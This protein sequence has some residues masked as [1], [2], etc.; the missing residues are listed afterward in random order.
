MSP[1][2][3]GEDDARAAIGADHFESVATHLTTTV[4]SHLPF[5]AL[6]AYKTKLKHYFSRRPWT[7]HDEAALSK[8][9]APYVPEG[10]WHYEPTPGLAI[11][12]GTVDGVYA[13]AAS[14]DAEMELDPFDRVFSG[15]VS[16]EPTPHPRKVRFIFGGPQAPGAWYLQGEPAADPRAQAL[17]ADPQVS[18]VMI[19]GDFVTIGLGPGASWRDRL[20]DMVERVTELFA[21]GADRAADIRTRDELLHDAAGTT[22]E[23]TE[24]HLLDPD[25]PDHRSV[26]QRALTATDYKKRRTAVAV[27]AQSADVA[28]RDEAIRRGYEDTHLSVRRTAIDEAREDRDRGLL[29]GALHD[30]DPWTR[31]RAVRNLSDLGIAE[32]TDDVGALEADENFQVRFEVARALKMP[33]PNEEQQ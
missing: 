7:A 5:E 32:S 9:V 12:H 33:P 11:E 14:G 20:D 6:V 16:P 27:L 26:L 19:A 1:L 31:W 28:V 3:P 15:P 10:S 23:R 21:E 2:S 29:E 25:R 18:D 22:S 13:L 30:R 17:L 4:A 24:L 8:L